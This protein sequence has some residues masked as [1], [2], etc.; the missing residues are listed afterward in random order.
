MRIFLV[1]TKQYFSEVLWFLLSLE[2][3]FS[4]YGG[5]MHTNLTL[6]S[7]SIKGCLFASQNDYL[8][9]KSV[10]WFL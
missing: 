9:K 8:P 7:H 5:L 1:L 2:C 4:F 6:G 3:M 10:E